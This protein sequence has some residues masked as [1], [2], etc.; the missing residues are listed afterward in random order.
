MAFLDQLG[1]QVTPVVRRTDAPRGRTP[2]VAAFCRNGKISAISAVMVSPVRRRC[3]LTFQLLPDHTNVHGEDTMA[4]LGRPRRRLQ[5][6]MTILWGQ[7]RIRRRSGVVK[8]SLARHPEVAPEEF[9]GYAADAN[10]EEGAS[11]WT[12][13]HRSPDF[14]PADLDEVRARLHGELPAPSKGGDLLSSFI[15][16]AEVPLRL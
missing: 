5:G 7:S 6:P 14:A 16:R 12:K 13:G 9:P 2:I 15:R 10:P 8:T 11:V 3:G 1:S 4:F